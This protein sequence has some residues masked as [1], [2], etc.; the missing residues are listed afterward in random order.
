MC[1]MKIVVNRTLYRNYST[2]I[3]I[4]VLFIR[5]ILFFVKNST[6]FQDNLLVL[7]WTKLKFIVKLL[8]EQM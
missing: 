4:T 6:L 5:N 7:S 1:K 8:I 2:A 3:G